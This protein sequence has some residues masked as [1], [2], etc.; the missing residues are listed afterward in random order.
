MTP[1]R[2]TLLG[3][4]GAAALSRILMPWRPTPK[5]ILLADGAPAGA[6]GVADFSAFDLS[7]DEAS[8]EVAPVMD[9]VEMPPTVAVP[10]RQGPYM[11]LADEGGREFGFV[12]S[13]QMTFTRAAH[14]GRG[15][16]P[17]I[18]ATLEVAVTDH[19]V[20]QATARVLPGFIRCMRVNDRSWIS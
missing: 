11:A 13:Y 3:A 2:R 1:T 15:G 9:S 12:H 4:A 5:D 19:E 6:V 7:A 14:R 10:L 17:D 18:R 8:P 20:F 16:R